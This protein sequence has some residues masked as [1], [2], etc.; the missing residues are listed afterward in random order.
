LIRRICEKCRTEAAPPAELVAEFFGESPPPAPLF[1]GA[2]CA[3]CGF[4][5]YRGRMIVAD[6]WTPDQADLMLIARQAPFDEIR[7]SATRTT[8]TMAQD[9]HERLIAGRTTLEELVRVLPY[10][11]I[12]EHRARYGGGT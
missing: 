11:S 9:A 1:R 8:I 7:Q 6:L 10:P 3:A 12:V 5:G 4:S 2:G